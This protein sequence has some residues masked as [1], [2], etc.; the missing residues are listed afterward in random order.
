MS[1]ALFELCKCYDFVWTGICAV[2]VIRL[3]LSGKHVSEKGEV[4]GG[5][6][7]VDY[8]GRNGEQC[9]VEAVERSTVAWQEAAAVFDAELALELAFHKVSPGAEDADRQTE[10]EPEPQVVVV[11][12][13][14]ETCRAGQYGETA[15]DAAYP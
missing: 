11:R 9:A 13:I 2:G 6:T 7:D 15:A 5:E 1:G 12:E 14:V 8:C 10:T 4:V 3:G